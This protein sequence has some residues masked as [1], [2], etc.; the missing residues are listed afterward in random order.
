[1]SSIKAVAFD[2]DGTLYPN[3]RMYAVSASLLARNLKLFRAFY[4]V[5]TELR[6]IRPINNFYDTQTMMVAEKMGRSVEETQALIT[7]EFYTKWE[8]VFHH[9]NLHS[10][11]IETFSWLEKRGIILA[12][13]SDF[14]VE[15]KLKILNIEN[16]FRVALCSETVGYLKPAPEPFNA[17][18]EKLNVP[19]KNLLYVGNSYE[20]DVQGAARLGIRTAH[21]ARRAPPC[22]P[23]DIT[24]SRYA[25]LREWLKRHLEK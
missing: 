2:I 21:I 12:V 17:L 3:S 25:V 11:V 6:N 23:A 15:T 9:V 7:E 8:K 18:L 20:Y 4:A 24:F 19:P 16:Y 10:G 14:P 5:R 13:L 1:M 22:S